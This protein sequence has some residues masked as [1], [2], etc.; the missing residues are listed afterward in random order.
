MIHCS[1]YAYFLLFRIP[2]SAH[3]IEMYS[4]SESDFMIRSD[5]VTE[6]D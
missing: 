3:L 5:S 2:L 4:F 1:V 6:N